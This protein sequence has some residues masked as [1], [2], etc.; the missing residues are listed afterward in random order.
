MCTYLSTKV[1]DGF[2]GE[3]PSSQSSKRKQPRI[4]PVFNDAVSDELLD[5]PL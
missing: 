4:I 3:T 1:V 5:L 2:R